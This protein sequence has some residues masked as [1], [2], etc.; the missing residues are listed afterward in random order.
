MIS[1]F[2]IILMSVIVIAYLIYNFIFDKLHLKWS[3]KIKPDDNN[4]PII[5]LKIIKLNKSGHIK[6]KLL[7]LEETG[8]IQTEEV[9]R[10]YD[11]FESIEINVE[12]IQKYEDITYIIN[13]ADNIVNEDESNILLE[14]IS[15]LI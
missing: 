12:S 1:L 10:K 4:L 15:S 3:I 2:I 9:P 7:K 8:M 11:D 6:Y 5:E 13:N 14:L